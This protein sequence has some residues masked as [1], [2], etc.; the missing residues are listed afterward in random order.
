MALAP[1]RRLGGL[2][3]RR[4][5]PIDPFVGDFVCLEAKLLVELD[6]KQHDGSREDEVRTAILR[7]LGFEVIRFPNERVRMDIDAVCEEIRRAARARSPARDPSSRRL[8]TGTP[9]PSAPRTPSLTRG[10]G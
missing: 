7:R 4:Q 3:F 1:G 6:G 5:H 9:H 2:K 10:G 8:T